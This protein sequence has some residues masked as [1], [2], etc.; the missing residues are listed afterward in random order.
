MIIKGTTLRIIQGDLLKQPVE[1][2][3]N[4]ANPSIEG[5]GGVDGA[6]HR[7]AG[8]ELA[9]ACRLYKK[10]QGIEKIE[11]GD[12]V[13]TESFGIREKNPEIRYVIHT[14]GPN[15]G[16]ASQNKNKEILLKKAYQNSL[17]RAREKEIRSIAFPAISTGIY[18]YPFKEAQRTAMKAIE[19]YVER[20]AGFFNEIYLTYY[21]ESDFKSAQL[22]WDELSTRS[23]T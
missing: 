21:S 22:I 20:H 16:V 23:S 19:E 13:L 17:E 11:V 4:A 8:P 18:S 2:I 9:E 14:V 3:V 5:G 7:A 12:A 6:I 10:K 1:A 15:C